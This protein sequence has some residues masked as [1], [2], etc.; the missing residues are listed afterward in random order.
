MRCVAI[1]KAH[2]EYDN[3]MYSSV[4]A[5]IGTALMRCFG[6]E[7]ISGHTFAPSLLREVGI[8]VDFGTNRGE[9]AER[10]LA[11]H[12]CRYYAVEA[13]PSLARGTAA[14]LGITVERLAIAGVDGEVEFHISSN[15]ESSSIYS[16]IASP[17]TGERVRVASLT[18]DSWIQ[19]HG[20]RAISLLKVD[21][22][23]AELDL[24]E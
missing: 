18:Y 6:L 9:F 14:R 10:F 17:T 16:T 22:E 21:I 19:R 5:F 2:L 24:L 23:D 3:I 4:R 7:T 12:S 8:V 13:D 20:I 11:R 15:P 1:P